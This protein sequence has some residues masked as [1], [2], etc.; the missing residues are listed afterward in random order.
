MR[1]LILADELFASR[2]R[3]MLHRL[4]VGF[5]D[6]GHRVIHALP[7]HLIPRATPN[8]DLQVRTVGYS[9][10]PMPM[11]DRLR[12]TVLVR[13]LARIADDED[14]D[15]HKPVDVVHVFGG[16]VWGLGQRIAGLIGAGLA[17]EVW[18]L[19]LTER[20][21]SMVRS[22][23]SGSIPVFLAPD[24]RIERALRDEGP[25]VAVRLVPWGVHTPAEPRE[26]L[27]PKRLPALMIVG[28][29]RDAAT[30]ASLVRSLGVVRAAGHEFTAF[31]DARAAQRAGVWAVAHET[32][33]LDCISLIEE[34][35]GRRD[36]LLHG[37][38]LI[39]PDAS[40][41]QRTI[42][43][44]AM[45]SGLAVVASEDPA[46][47]ILRERETA[48]LVRTSKSKPAPTGTL[49]DRWAEAITRV[50]AKPAEATALARAARQFVRTDRQASA[51]VR[52]VL[53][54]YAALSPTDSIPFQAGSRS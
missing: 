47:E 30:Y 9:D 34:L 36:L 26:I 18:R 17:L 20:A 41:E 38:I 51:Q 7:D 24:R 1:I 42:V 22:A 44:E 46:V 4:E 23:G 48:I 40:G 52:G 29:G 31:L 49:Q 35:E 15:T 14:A 5:V 53:E 25:G 45:A 6:E 11:A 37:D 28:T 13:T 3:E 19:G 10:L 54:C 50:L 16:G 12:S 33:L 43:L 32:G 39:H 27:N 8:Q 2:E 21:A